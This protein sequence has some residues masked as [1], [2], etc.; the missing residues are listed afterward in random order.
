[1]D[2][3][4]I[5]TLL[6]TDITPYNPLARFNSTTTLTAN[7]RSAIVFRIFRCIVVWPAWVW[8]NAARQGGC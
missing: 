1:M 8:E 2:V 5:S 4:C 6:Y 3:R 7:R